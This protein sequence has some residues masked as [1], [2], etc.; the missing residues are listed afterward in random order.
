M[1]DVAPAPDPF[2]LELGRLVEKH[3][4]SRG[5]SQESLGK[6]VSLKRASISNIECGRQRIYLHTIYLLAAALGTRVT[7]LLPDRSILE[8]DI[9]RTMLAQEPVGV[10]SQD[11]IFSVLKGEK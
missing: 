3:R 10:E 7:S 6:Q 9:L 11:L 4:Q 5:M 8:R 1:T 2:Y